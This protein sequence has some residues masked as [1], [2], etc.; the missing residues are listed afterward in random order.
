MG[1]VAKAL[2][3]RVDLDELASPTGLSHWLEQIRNHP[4]KNVL[5][6][7][8]LRSL[9]QAVYDIANIGH[10]GLASDAYLHFTSPIRRY[11]DLVVHRTVKHVLRGG[12]IDTSPQAV[13]DL[14]GA[15]TAA[16]TRERA[17]MEVEREVVDLYRALL[18]RA[19][20]GEILEGS[21]TAVVGSG[22]YVA[23]DHPFVDVLV[24][25]EGL[26]PDHYE[27][28]ENELGVVGARS[29]D[30]VALGDRVLVEIEDVAI[31]RRAVFA[32]RIPPERVLDDLEKQIAKDRA[33]GK[34]PA[35]PT[36]RGR[37]DERPKQGGHKT[38]GRQIPRKTRRGR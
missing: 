12:K 35:R 21:V 31:L 22:V 30:T 5:E 27:M 24:R 7:L 37:R 10:F 33:R 1:D 11:P 26:G 34:R 17:A 36:D 4:K 2:D 20:I 13:E 6:M 3:V 14:R 15:A 38:R 28:T 19:R 16:S 29:G 18:M 8:L 25:F 23:L 32:R 9:K